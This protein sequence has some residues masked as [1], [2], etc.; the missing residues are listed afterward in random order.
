MTDRVLIPHDEDLAPGTWRLGPPEGQPVHRCPLCKAA[1]VMVNHS[2]SSTG[3]VNASIA[4]FAP[5]T[6]HVFGILGGWTHGEKPAG[7][8]VSTFGAGPTE[9]R[10]GGW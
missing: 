8:R 6:Y 5:C 7:G 1:A 9:A 2:V 3:E 4:C 10:H